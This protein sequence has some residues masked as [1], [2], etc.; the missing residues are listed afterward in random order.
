MQIQFPCCK[1]PSK[2]NF[3]DLWL[4]SGINVGNVVI[5]DILL[6]IL[7]SLTLEEVLLESLY[8]KDITFEIIYLDC[9]STLL[10]RVYSR[11]H[12]T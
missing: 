1:I 8:I 2:S 7:R 10:L 3:N 9:L 11:S 5:R 4:Q 6:L 12:L